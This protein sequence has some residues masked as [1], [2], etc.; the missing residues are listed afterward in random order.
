[1]IEMIFGNLSIVSSIAVWV[2]FAIW[3]NNKTTEN[4]A[5]GIFAACFLISTAYAVVSG[6]TWMA[7]F[8]AGTAAWC[9]HRSWTLKSARPNDH[10]GASS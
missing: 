1:M 7:A 3:R 8:M 4:R 2:V 6:H 10:P 5:Y 9:A